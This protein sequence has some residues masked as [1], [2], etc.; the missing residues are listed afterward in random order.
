MRD[1]KEDVQALAS[2]IARDWEDDYFRTNTPTLLLNMY[3][4]K[5]R[6][7]QE[8]QLTFIAGFS[9]NLTRSHAS[10]VSYST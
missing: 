9:N 10:L 2:M 7:L 5:L 1:A 8:A 3:V 6:S 4:N